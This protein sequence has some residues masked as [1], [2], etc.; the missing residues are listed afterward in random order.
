M[1]KI[2]ELRIKK[3]GEGQINLS[4]ADL[5]KFSFDLP[6]KIT[7][8]FS[9]SISTLL[10][11]NSSENWLEKYGKLKNFYQ[12]NNSTKVS[13]SSELWNWCSMQRL[14]KN[15]NRLSNE[16]IKRLEEFHDWS[17]D[18]LEDKWQE[19]YEL[20][21]DFL[22]KNGTDVFTQGIDRKMINNSLNKWVIAQR[23]K[24]K[25]GELDFEKVALLNKLNGWVWDVLDNYWN[26]RFEELKTFSIENDNF[27]SQ[28][29]ELGRWISSQRGLFSKKTLPEDKIKKLESVNGWAWDAN[30]FIWDKKF[31]ELKEYI[32]YEKNTRPPRDTSLGKWV[33]QQRL[34]YRKGDLSNQRINLLN[35]L[36]YWGWTANDARKKNLQ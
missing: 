28:E 22:Q 14:F 9:D 34:I 25:Q 8:K 12:N 35:Q 11:Q 18:L 6:E 24:Y 19:N 10:V 32:K 7:S 17:W 21:R 15:K 36:S 16:R 33:S 30:K 23:T 2:D 20:T 5:K 31:N 3:G 26:K 27:P 4:D 1:E 29:S 13:T